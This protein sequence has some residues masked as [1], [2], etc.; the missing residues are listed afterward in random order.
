MYTL[1]S[2]LKNVLNEY[3][4]LV[5]RV[6]EDTTTAY[7]INAKHNPFYNQCFNGGDYA[8]LVVNWQLLFSNIQD[9][10]PNESN[11]IK[12]KI[13][14]GLNKMRP[15]FASWSNSVPLFRASRLLTRSERHSLVK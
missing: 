3:R 15:L 13:A 4:G 11:A 1:L 14:N 6:M 8:R 10:Y 5:E 2:E 9:T 7:P 12:E